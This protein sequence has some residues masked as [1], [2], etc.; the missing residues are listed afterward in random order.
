MGGIQRRRIACAAGMATGA[1]K[2]H[3]END[4]EDIWLGSRI[5]FEESRN[6]PKPP[7]QKG[8]QSHSHPRIAPRAPFVVMR[9]TLGLVACS[10]WLCAVHGSPAADPLCAGATLTVGLHSVSCEMQ[11]NAGVERLEWCAGEDLRR[12]HQS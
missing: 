12:P 4:W 3:S 7:V 1:R 11:H 10:L 9:T 2:A 5:T 8:E 6:P